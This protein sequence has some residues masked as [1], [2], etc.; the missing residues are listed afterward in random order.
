RESLGATRSGIH[1]DQ[2]KMRQNSSACARS[3]WRSGLGRCVLDRLPDAHIRAAAADVT[4]HGRVD[5]GVI[6]VWDGVKQGRRRHD[7]ARLAIAALNDFQV[8]PRL[9][10]FGAVGRSADAL[11]GG[12]R[13]LANR[14][15]RQKAGADGLTVHMDG[16]GTTLSY[17]APELGA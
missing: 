10:H 14:A 15:H 4:G 5:V 7:L 17:A 9:L 3:A 16:A 6:R 13:S 12:D 2:R 8:Q 1:W 11:D